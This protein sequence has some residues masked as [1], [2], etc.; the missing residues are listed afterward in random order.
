MRVIVVN[1]SQ[2]AT[3]ISWKWGTETCG[4]D[5]D[6]VRAPRDVRKNVPEI[7][8]GRRFNT[9]ILVDHPFD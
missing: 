3:E 8:G 9:L 5:P 1:Q 7:E 6:H 4:I 2:T